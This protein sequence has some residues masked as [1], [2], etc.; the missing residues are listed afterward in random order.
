M[1]QSKRRGQN[2]AHGEDALILPTT[3]FARRVIGALF[4]FVVGVDV[5]AFGVRRR[6]ADA[7]AETAIQQVEVQPRIGN[8]FIGVAVF[9]VVH[10]EAVDVHS[11]GGPD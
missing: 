7:I 10:A 8:K 9:T 3:V 2:L 6:I 1:L 5:Q 4:K 11:T